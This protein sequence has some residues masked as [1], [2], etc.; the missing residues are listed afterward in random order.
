MDGLKNLANSAVEGAAALIE[1]ADDAISAVGEKT[2][3]GAN[4]V[5]DTA[6]QG[7]DAAKEQASV[8]GKCS[9]K[10]LNYITL[11]VKLLLI[12]TLTNHNNLCTNN[13]ERS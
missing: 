11:L 13:V 8:V 12:V 9:P 7:V 10:F 6:S 2:I 4:A 1:K 3:D 5:V